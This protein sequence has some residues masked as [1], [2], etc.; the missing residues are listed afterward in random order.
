MSAL[1]PPVVSPTLDLP[2]MLSV[3]IT[4]DAKV[5]RGD[6]NETASPAKTDFLKKSRRLILSIY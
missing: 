6:A 3:L 5:S 4:D 1:L 2:E